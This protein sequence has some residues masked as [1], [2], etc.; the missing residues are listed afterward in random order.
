MQAEISK[1]LKFHRITEDDLKTLAEG[2]PYIRKVL[3]KVLDLFYAHVQN[4]PETAQ[5]FKSKAHIDHAKSKQAEH[6]SFLAKA[7]LTD[8]YVASVRRIGEAH[9]KLGMSPRYYI[10]AYNY[11]SGAIC[12]ELEAEIRGGV[13]AARSG[14]FLRRLQQAVIK[15]TFLDMDIALEVYEDAKTRDRQNFIEGI[16]SR[17]EESVGTVA[18]SLSA[19]AGGLKATSD[20]LQ[21]AAS[22]TAEISSTVEEAA[23]STSVNVE[24]VSHST[25]E[26]AQAIAEIA[27]QVNR[28]ATTADQAVTASE[29]A[30]ARVGALTV[31]AD[32]IGNII[33]LINKISS[34][35]HLLALNATIE[36][37]RAGEAGKGFSVVAHEVKSL[38][39]QTANATV[40]IS[41]Q[42]AEIQ[43]ATR[44]SRES[45]E[46]ISTTIS[47]MDA[48]S[49]AI[50]GAV[51]QQGA[52]TSVISESI[53]L[54]AEG[55]SRV[56]SGITS[57]SAA[58]GET[59]TT[60]GNV[61][62]SANQLSEYARDLEA[63]MADFL[64]HLRA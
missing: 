25:G 20:T 37:A 39:E 49:A 4:F 2:E 18:G 29:K 48:I 17:F 62:E 35:T 11:L 56:S 26:L 58:A 36:A 46:E 22:E 57:V 45:M 13:L 27:Q 14:S 44:H 23:G 60:A 21:K 54:A 30:I 15:V 63:S 1:R 16:A 24:S 61:L 10:G 42:I 47:E 43:E 38:A 34:Q 8:D 6:W 7:K 55:T 28:A 33:E 3:P 32:E 59:G 64:G 50:S 51:E 52:A 53:S 40:Q 12:S 9:N 5:F 19:A 31:A 41:S